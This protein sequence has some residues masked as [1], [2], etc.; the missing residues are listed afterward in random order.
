MLGFIHKLEKEFDT[1][2]LP[3]QEQIKG[4]NTFHIDCDGR[5]KSLFLN[6]VNLENLNILLPIAD[7]IT[8]LS[9]KRGNI[10]S[11]VSIN[12]FPNIEELNLSFNPIS[13]STLE[14]L[15][16]VRNLKKLFLSGT[17]IEDTTALGGISSLEKLD[18]SGSDVLNEISGLEELRFL[19]HIDVGLTQIEKIEKIHVHQAIRSIYVNASRIEEISGLGRFPYLEELKLNGN[20]ISKIEGLDQSKFLKKLNIA[21]LTIGQIEGL[22]NLTSLEMLDL[23]DNDLDKI[24]G[25]DTLVNLKQLNLNDNGIQKVENLGNLVNL[26]YL[27]LARNKIDEFDTRFLAN[28][29]S[30]CFIALHGNHIKELKGVIP[31]NVEVQLHAESWMPIGLF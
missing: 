23:C 7:S 12:S 13:T 24:Q 2:I 27:L 15:T 11:L 1:E 31:E 26:E 10:K 3:S 28:L 16:H 6:K 29:N 19:D 8:K 5:V 20:P 22:E 14:S 18:L 17:N 25:L 4:K 21:S 30:P 9:I